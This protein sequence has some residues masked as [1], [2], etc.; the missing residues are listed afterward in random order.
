MGKRT[1]YLV[2]HGQYRLHE[3]DAGGLTHKGET[4]ARMTGKAI[5]HLPF[6]KV[7]S[8]PVLRAVQTADIITESL[9]STERYEDELLRECIPSIPLRYAA[10]FA[11]T[12]PELTESRINDCA[13]KLSIAFEGYFRRNLADHDVHEL[14]VCHGNVIRY[15]VARVLQTD[16]DG[17][18]NMIIHNCGITRVLIDSDGQLF[19]ISHNDIGHLPED[20]RTDN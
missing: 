5:A 3:R 10:Y 8:S 13:D 20:L 6:T 9:G 4:Q 11:G 15:F 2:R 17:W 18:S 12:H 14:L 19:L 7:I 1:L 16:S